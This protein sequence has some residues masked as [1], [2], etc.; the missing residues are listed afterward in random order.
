MKI[1]T[2]LQNVTDTDTLNKGI[3]RTV[4]LANT[5]NLPLEFTLIKTTKQFTSIP[6]SNATNTNG[7]E[8]NP[9][10]IFQEAKVAGLP[11]DIDLLVYDWTTVTPQPTN[12]TDAGMNIQIPIQWYVTYPEVF[13]M[14][15]LHELSHY[16][17]SGT[18]KTDITHLMTDGA[19]QAQYPV[20]YEKY[21]NDPDQWY[22]YLIKSL[23]TPPQVSTTNVLP[24]VV[25]TRSSDDGVQTL[26]DLSID[27]FSCKTL[28]RPW[29]NNAVNVSCIPK[30]TYHV[31]WTFSLSHLGWTY[32]L[33]NVP[34]R[35]GIRIHVA[36][37]YFDLEG[38]I[39]LGDSFE[40]INS[41]K[42]IDLKNSRLTI[43][44][45]VAKMGK[46]DFMLTIK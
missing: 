25:I 43:N 8:I 2:L 39:G 15:F 1:L 22:L 44:A 45:F 34:G 37:Y 4:Q 21:K 40:T 6:F 35:A 5:I 23:Y 9:T 30:G 24:Q 18:G 27:T 20:E 41:D 46:K 14:Y 11:F 10:E 19:L 13:A 7:Y 32:Q 12:P 33:Q 28:E 26:G 16:F 36:N 29:K 31:K 3:A 17:F 38:C 42:E